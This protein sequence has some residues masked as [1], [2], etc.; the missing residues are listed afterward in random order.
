MAV[1]RGIWNINPDNISRMFFSLGCQ[2]VFGIECD[3]VAKSDM[4][5]EVVAAVKAHA[6][7]VHKEKMKDLSKDTDAVQL[8]DL[9]ENGIKEDLK[10][11]IY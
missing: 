1:L 10:G 3:Y 5:Q 11:S 8:L 7:E 2:D 6:E 9:L 4:R